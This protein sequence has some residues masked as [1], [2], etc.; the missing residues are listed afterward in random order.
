MPVSV[1][2]RPYTLVPGAADCTG[3]ATATATYAADSGHTLAFRS[4]A[5]DA[6]GN[7]EV[8]ASGQDAS[9]YV[10]DF[11]PPTTAVTAV[12][13]SKPAFV[14]NY[15]GT[16][17]GCSGVTSLDVYAAIDGGTPRSI[18][19]LPAPA[20]DAQGYFQGQ[21]GYSAIVDGK[22]HDFRFIPSA[23]T[24]PATSSSRRPSAT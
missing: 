20:V 21:V 22:S 15:G 14:V 5:T 13:A 10:P 16:D 8:K 18:A 11:D 4:V 7:A 24:E 17:P 19:H 23:P 9:T 2:G 3:H 12:D 1:D 6:V